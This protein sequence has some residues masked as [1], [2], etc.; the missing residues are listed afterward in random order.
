MD[1]ASVQSSQSARSRRAAAVPKRGDDRARLDAEIA[2]LR[3]RLADDESFRQ[4]AI[5]LVAGAL[6][7]GRAEARRL[8]EEGGKGLAC[9]A[10]I[11]DLED[12]IIVAIHRLV[13]LTLH[14]AKSSPAAE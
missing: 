12:E 5:G 2:A 7:E 9:A 8:L 6:A 3:D 1:S 14:L 10:R 13:S 11:S 4:A